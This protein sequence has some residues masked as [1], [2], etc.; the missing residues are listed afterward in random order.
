M[1]KKWD[2]LGLNTVGNFKIF[3]LSYI[4]R[5]HPDRNSSSDFVVLNSPRWVNIIPV[6]ESGNIVM[7][8]Q[9]RHGVD[10][11]TLEVPGGL[12]EASELPADAAKRECQEE[13]GYA[14]EADVTLLGEIL[15]NP[16][17]LDNICYSYLWRGCRLVSDQNLDRHEDIQVHEFTKEQIREMI[18]DGRINHSLVL[19]AFFYYN[20]KYGL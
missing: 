16:A 7:I 3:D 13:T 15:P 18:L 19:N 4:N 1:I 9:Y 12:V 14:S 8:E 5:K 10:A 2:T 11:V 17:F 6:T 20:L